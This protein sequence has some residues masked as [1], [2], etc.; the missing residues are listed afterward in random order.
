MNFCVTIYVLY[1]YYYIYI[2]SIYFVLQMLDLCNGV[3]AQSTP[4][5]AGLNIKYTVT[6]HYNF[7]KENTCM[8]VCGSYML[9]WIVFPSDN[10]YCG[11]ETTIN[12][13]AKVY[14]SIYI[15]SPEY[16]GNTLKLTWLMQ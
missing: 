3:A 15:I 11:I 14:V 10:L 1:I 6:I 2:Y 7:N 9:C 12:L 16:E 4:S 8:C 5:Q 13:C